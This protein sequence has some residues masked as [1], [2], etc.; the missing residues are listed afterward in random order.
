MDACQIEIILTRGPSVKVKPQGNNL[1]QAARIAL[2]AVQ[3]GW[4]LETAKQSYQTVHCGR[5]VSWSDHFVDELKRGLLV[6]RVMCV[7]TPTK[8]R[9]I[10]TYTGYQAYHM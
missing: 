8:I 4:K 5:S 2:C 6:C 1:P 3:N 9:S 7:Y 10:R